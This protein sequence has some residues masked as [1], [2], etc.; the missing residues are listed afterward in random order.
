MFYCCIERGVDVHDA[1]AP[2]G[3]YACRLPEEMGGDRVEYWKVE[4]VDSLSYSDQINRA[5][6]PDQVH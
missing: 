1:V 6:G 3:Y 4:P 5:L 2:D